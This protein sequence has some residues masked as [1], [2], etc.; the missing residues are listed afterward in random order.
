MNKKIAISCA[1]IALVAFVC[2]GLVYLFGDKEQ[3]PSKETVES[4]TEESITE[5]TEESTEVVESTEYTGQDRELKFDNYVTTTK[6]KDSYVENPIE[7]NS[8]DVDVDVVNDYEFSNGF[9]LSNTENIIVSSYG[10]NAGELVGQDGTHIRVKEED[11]LK[12]TV[13]TLRAQTLE[14]LGFSYYV[15]VCPLDIP[16]DAKVTVGEGLSDYEKYFELEPYKDPTIEDWGQVLCDTVIDTAFGS[17]LYTEIYSP[18]TKMYTAYVYILCERERI[19]NIIIRG[20][21]R[22]YLLPYLYEL[23]ND[24]ISLIK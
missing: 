16:A 6:G 13:Q 19:L 11:A 15:A 22:D 8:K 4:Q 7:N 1:I 14:D 24:S 9:M 23:T 3:S 21:N 2:V 20:E 10:F 5:S 18:D 12:T 17:A